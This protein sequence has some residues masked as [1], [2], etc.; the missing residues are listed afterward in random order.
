MFRFLLKKFVLLLL[1]L[2]LAVLVVNSSWFLKIYYPYPH[3][4]LVDEHCQKY[5][6]DPLLVMAII[7]TESKFSSQAH[8][9]VGAKG[10][11]QIMPETGAWI[12][13]QM[14]I[15]NFTEEMLFKPEY[16]IPMGIWYIS[17]LE[18]TFKGDLSVILAAYNAGE[19]KVRTW[20]TEGIWT[21][22]QQDIDQI[23]YRETRKYVDKVLFD[24]AV[25]KRIYTK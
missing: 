11:M 18:R 8:S 25:Y 5:D 4:E 14:K 1:L 21:G 24:Y 15:S 9:R 7:R 12:A 16:N 6:I 22:K 20:L 13:K 23:P 2:L 10:L 3:Q 19:R 17:Y